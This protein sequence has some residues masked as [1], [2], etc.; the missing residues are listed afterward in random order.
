MN[1]PF[2]SLCLI[3]LGY[4]LIPALPIALMNIIQAGSIIQVVLC[5]AVKINLWIRS[6]LSSL[7]SESI[8]EVVQNIVENPEPKHKIHKHISMGFQ[9]LIVSYLWTKYPTSIPT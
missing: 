2:V 9:S 3:C 7:A 5:K 1:I 6:G 8:Q 4:C